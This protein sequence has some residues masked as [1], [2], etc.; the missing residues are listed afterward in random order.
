MIFCLDDI[1]GPPPTSST[2]TSTATSSTLLTLSSLRLWLVCHSPVVGCV[3]HQK[4][5]TCNLGIGVISPAA[6][7]SFMPLM[8]SRKYCPSCRIVCLADIASRKPDPK[9]LA[10]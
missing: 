7:I 3:G 9:K 1:A 2:R 4:L 10:H 5:V 8:G 6:R